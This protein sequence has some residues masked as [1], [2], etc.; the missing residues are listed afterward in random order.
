MPNLTYIPSR[1]L[2]G[3][4]GSIDFDLERLDRKSKA[5]SK[6]NVP[7]A[8]GVGETIL[9]NIEYTY[10]CKTTPFD[11]AL[12]PYFREWSSSTMGGEIFTFDDLGT[13]A[14]PV[15]PINVQLVTNSYSET[16]LSNQYFS[17]AFK[18]KTL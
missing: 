13:A 16:R 12:L 11:K 3:D 4:G 10:Q 18:L 9:H 5:S 14:I 1:E 15:N 17:V 8:G 7:L 2:V 6:T